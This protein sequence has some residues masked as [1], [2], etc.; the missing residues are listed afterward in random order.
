[1]Y[2][3]RTESYTYVRI[4]AAYVEIIY[5]KLIETKKWIEKNHKMK[6][7]EIEKK[8]SSTGWKYQPGLNVP[9]LV[10]CLRTHLGGV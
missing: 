6:T 2:N 10:Q 9:V 7:K 8:P 4:L 5:E 3:A 1:M